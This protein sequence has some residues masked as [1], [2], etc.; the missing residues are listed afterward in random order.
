MSSPSQKYFGTVEAG[1][2]LKV[3]STVVR[4]LLN[5]MTDPETEVG[6]K[7]VKVQGV[8]GEPR[9][10][11]IRWEIPESAIPK[12]QQLLSNKKKR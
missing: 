9:G 12:L 6:A 3:S 7:L 1:L 11:R 4:H 8:A 5:K 2:R 10:P